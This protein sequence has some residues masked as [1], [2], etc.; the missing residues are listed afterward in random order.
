MHLSFYTP[1]NPLWYICLECATNN[2]RCLDTECLEILLSFD[3]ISFFSMVYGSVLSIMDNFSKY[4]AFVTL[5]KQDNFTGG[6]LSIDFS[7]VCL[8]R[9]RRVGVAKYRVTSART[10]YIPIPGLLRALLSITAK[11]T[12]IVWYFVS[13]KH[14]FIEQKRGKQKYVFFLF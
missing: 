11:S 9:W 6:T 14:Y 2:S 1:S 13:N 4:L 10:L 5:S 7:I 12:L 3:S 8:P